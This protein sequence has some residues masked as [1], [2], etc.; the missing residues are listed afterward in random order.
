MSSIECERPKNMQKVIVQWDIP[1][2]PYP[3]YKKKPLDLF[4]KKK[5]RQGKNFNPLLKC[6]KNEARIM[7]YKKSKGLW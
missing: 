7:G 4:L 1:P 3:N 5:K 6:V 2:P